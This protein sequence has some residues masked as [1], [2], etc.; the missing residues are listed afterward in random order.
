MNEKYTVIGGGIVGLSTA[1]ALA[2][3]GNPVLLLEQ[4]GKG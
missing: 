3:R 2:K 1:L 4:F